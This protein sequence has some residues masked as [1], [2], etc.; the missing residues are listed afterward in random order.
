[1]RVDDLCLVLVTSL[2]Q[3]DRARWPERL[4]ALEKELGEGWSLRRLAVPRVYSLG[5]Q[6]RDGRELSL[7]DWLEQLA[8]NEPV[9]A[10]VVDFGS[11]APD[12]L[13]AHIAAAFANTG[14]TVMEVTS[15]GASSHFLLRTH[16]SRP[17]LLTPQRLVEFARAQPHADRIFEAWA[18]SVSENNEMNG[19]PAVPV[20]EVADYLASPA[21]FV[22]YDLR[23]NELL[24]E[25]QVALRKQGS[26]VSV[27]DAFKAAFYTS[28][29]D[30]M[31]RGFMSPEQQAEYVPREEQL[32]VTEA[33]TPQQFADLVDAQPFAQDAW[34]RIVQD[35][36]QFLPEGT[37]PDTVESLP[38]RLRA[39]PSDGLQS[40][41]TG[42]MMEALQRA[43]RAQG[44]TLTLP[45]P[46]RGC[47]DLM[48]PVD[49]DAIP[50]KD[51]LRLQSN[52]DVYQMFLF[53]ELGDGLSPV[54]NGPAWDDARRAFIEVLRDAGRFASEQGSNFAPAFKLALFALEGQSPSYG[55]LAREPMQAHLDAAKAAGFDDEPLEVFGRKLGSLSLFIPLGLSEEKLRALLAYLLCDIFGGMGSWND[56]YFETPEAQ[57]QYEALSPR[58]FAALSRFFVATLNAR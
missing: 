10:R 4:E 29:P 32:R 16:P 45:E 8:P 3:G 9:S 43:G 2:L 18:A 25:L 57:Q 56:Q 52:P 19:R 34:S 17:Y 11:A 58:L 49:A 20:S 24:E 31:M 46:L 37:P 36:N 6:R 15:G 12:A 23:G 47:V 7:A 42:N 5:V 30:E 41:F 54:S 53:H 38:A 28:D 55:S 27:P 1:M 44:A 40:M 22:H 26:A 51:L 39:M 33:T 14:G 13:P 35:L 21:G 50:E 48:F